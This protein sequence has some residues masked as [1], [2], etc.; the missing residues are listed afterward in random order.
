M[1]TVKT[2]AERAPGIRPKLLIVDDDDGYRKFLKFRLT[3]TY[4]VI[5]VAS[6]EHALGK[7]VQDRPDCVLL[8]LF[9]PRYSGLELCGAIAS[10]GFTS[11]IPII[12]L[13]GQSAET[14]KK[15][16]LDLGAKDYFEKPV[17]IK[18]LKDRISELLQAKA[19]AR[20]VKPRIPVKMNLVLRGADVRGNY[21]EVRASTDNLSASGF[22]SVLAVPLE[23]GTVVEVE[24][25]PHSQ[26]MKGRAKVVNVEQP[27]NGL[28]VYSF[29]ITE[30]SG[31]WNLK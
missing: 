29:E 26:Q 3:D 31:E 22:G 1:E 16:C 20:S 25:L 24:L 4:D 23:V 2:S 18:R 7:V 9:M 8:D 30:K 19:E 6:P 5:D 12:V 27:E 21:F 15:F 14:Y 17:D 13:S 11:M 28:T 10:L